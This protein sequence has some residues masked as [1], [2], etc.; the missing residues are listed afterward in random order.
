MTRTHDTDLIETISAS[1]DPAPI[2]APFTGEHLVS[3]PQMTAH[4]IEIAFDRARAAQ[5]A[6]AQVPVAERARTVGRLL[7]VLWR[8][9]DEVFDVLQREGGKARIDAVFE[10]GEALLGT[11][12]HVNTAPGLLSDDKHAG[13][14]PIVASTRVVHQPHG[15]VA[16]IVPWNFPIALGAVDA[17]P[18]LLAGNAVLLKADNQTALS[19]LLL[20]RVATQVGIPHDVFQIVLGHRDEIGDALLD[21]ADYVAFT[22]STAAGRAIGRRAGERL[23]GCSLEL[24]GKNPMIVLPDADL[25]RAAAAIPRGSFGNT[26]QLCMTAERLYVHA[27]IADQLIEKIVERVAEIR[28][29]AGYDFEYDMGSITTAA[30]FDRLTGYVDQARRSGATVLTGGRARPD[31]GP[32]FFEPTVLTDVSDRAE[33]HREEVFGPILSV[34]TFD[35]VDEAVELA[36][37]TEYGLSASIWTRDTRHAR[38][39]ATRIRAGGVNINDVYAAAFGAHSAPA[40]GAKASGVGRRHGTA[41]LLRYTEAQT[42]AEQRVVSMQGRFGLPRRSHGKVLG[43]TLGLMKYLR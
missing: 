41:G 20:R 43:H 10:L 34:Y 22:G 26:G 4:D 7:D 39:L 32:Q 33:L 21:N 25:D 14:V 13:A 12:H 18:A 28:M 24:G 3:V 37:N 15:V 19:L 6:W 38:E 16:V 17:L 11:R 8:R 35:S 9:R 5:K 23:I 1:G 30:N 42:I 31:L 36:N 40:G 29:G 2:N 27:H